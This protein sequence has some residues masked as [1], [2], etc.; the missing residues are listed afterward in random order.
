MNAPPPIRAQS[1]VLNAVPRGLG[2][3]LFET[4]YGGWLELDLW[5]SYG[6]LDAK[7]YQ[8]AR[9]YADT[10]TERRLYAMVAR[11]VHQVMEFAG[12]ASRAGTHYR[13]AAAIIGELQ[14]QQT[15]PCVR[16]HSAGHRV[17]AGVPK[18][19]RTCKGRGMVLPSMSSR[20]DACQCRRPEFRDNLSGVYLTILSRL[21]RELANT[22]FE[23]RRAET[24]LANTGAGLALTG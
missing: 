21:R 9:C 15:R 24:A 16:C 7:G 19:C 22:T 20:A 12:A 13:I 6:N 14:G 2:R 1:A 5:E 4:L 8:F 17:V 18:P 11:M 23:Y 3:D 10:N